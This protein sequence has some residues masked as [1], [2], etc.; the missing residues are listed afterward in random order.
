[1]CMRRFHFE[2]NKDA[3]GVSG[4]GI[5]AEG[6]LFADSGE[7]VIHW[8]GEHSSINVYHSIDDVNYIHG[9]SGMTNIVFDDPENIS[10]KK[11]N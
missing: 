2:R 10:D 4:T 7:I 1:M 8:F 11:G 9:H 5:V 6:C 3:S